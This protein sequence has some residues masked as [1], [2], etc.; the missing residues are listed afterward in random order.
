MAKKPEKSG[1]IARECWLYSQVYPA[2]MATPKD[3]NIWHDGYKVRKVWLYSQRIL[4]LQSDNAG[5][6]AS[7]SEATQST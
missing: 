1:Y 6:I 2:T 4:A 7:G 5:Y 3:G